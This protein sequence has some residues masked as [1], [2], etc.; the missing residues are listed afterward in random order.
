MNNKP[1]YPGELFLSMTAMGGCF[2]YLLSRTWM[3]WGDLLVDSFREFWVP[4]KI[5]EGHVLYRDI[6]YEYGF[7]PPYF[8]A[9]LF[10][11]FGLHLHTLAGLGIVITL[12]VAVALYLISRL[13]L[14]IQASALTVIV[15]F[16]VFA[17]NHYF[18][19]NNFNFI[20]PYSFA[21]TFFL[22]FTLYAAYAFLK[23]VASGHY[24]CLLC[25][26]L[27]L[28]MAFFCR[29]EFALLVWGGF[30]I[31]GLPYAFKTDQQ[32]TPCFWLLL[33][34][35]IIAGFVGYALF[36]ALSGASQGFKECII[37]HILVLNGGAFQKLVMGT[38]NIGPNLK[39]TGQSILLTAAGLVWLAL[40]ATGLVYSK[41]PRFFLWRILVVMMSSAGIA[42]ACW[43]G[44]LFLQNI[45][46]RLLAPILTVCVFYYAWGL[47]K[48]PLDRYLLQRFCLFLLAFLLASRM[49]L[50]LSPA[51]YGF[52]LLVPGLL[53]YHIIIFTILTPG[54]AR[55]IPGT[56]RQALD[57][58]CIC[59]LLFL[60]MG[61]W[62]IS[63]RNYDQRTARIETAQGA[64]L[65]FDNEQTHDIF[66][67]VSYL[68]NNTPPDSSVVVF[69][70]GIAINVFSDRKNPLPYCNF[71][72]P[73]PRLTGDEKLITALMDHDV[74]YIVIV[75][76]ATYDYGAPFFGIHYAQVLFGWIKN[77]YRLE[78]IIGAMP[79]TSHR[80]GV[81]IYR[82]IRS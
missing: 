27:C 63:S 44:H 6:F 32:K 29:L 25:W 80:F 35:P 61:W 53:C 1:R 79:F 10:K 56:S 67:A 24:R 68:C 12:I 60:A 50:N 19:N 28:I 38:D 34:L 42:M 75:S 13:F 31:T 43:G 11:L 46:Y 70:E 36:V 54:L 41:K 77:N 30:F 55:I 33:F 21:A 74:E 58:A 72:P 3:K 9:L 48:T 23:F 20:F 2:F 71:T 37:D 62:T 65:W 57:F 73:V 40:C 49:L 47:L 76:R 26:A 81:A 64:F 51:W 5:L 66:Q 15:F 59:F 39:I 16:L 52:F 82:K 78:N 18:Y 8:Q 17:F 45:Q 14:N 4:M 22:L 69:P 7:F